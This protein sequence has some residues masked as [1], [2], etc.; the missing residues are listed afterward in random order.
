ME[1]T[2][3]FTFLYVKK[4]ADSDF[5]KLVDITDYP[6]LYSA[7]ERLDRSDLS[8]NSKHYVKG[9][10]DP[11]ELQFGYNYNLDD[12]KTIKAL[13]GLE[14]T[15]YQLRFGENGEFGAWQWTGDLFATPVGGAA[16]EVRKGSITMY[17]ASAIEMVEI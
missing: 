13:E 1:H 4:A 17:P 10:E 6:D 5:A 12:Y 14:D 9:M 3:S 2:T 7:P 16:N 15:Q 8:S 11:G